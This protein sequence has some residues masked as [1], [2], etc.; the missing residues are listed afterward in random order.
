MHSLWSTFLQQSAPAASIS[1]VY[2]LQGRN[3]QAPA[4]Y[5][6]DGTVNITLPLLVSDN[7]RPAD[8]DN[9]VLFK[10]GKPVTITGY[11]SLDLTEPNSSSIDSLAVPAFSSSMLDEE[12][13]PQW[14]SSAAFQQFAGDQLP[15]SS[16]A[17]GST[18]LR[19]GAGAVTFY[20]QLTAEMDR[21]AQ[22]AFSFL[23]TPVESFAADSVSSH[24][25]A[26]VP[27]VSSSS[28]SMMGEVDV[29]L[30]DNTSY[31]RIMDPLCQEV[32]LLEDLEEMS[33]PE[34]SAVAALTAARDE[35]I[36][37]ARCGGVLALLLIS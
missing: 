2:C 31:T 20:P 23:H 19:S 3:Q 29:M 9:A 35:A 5:N 15:T 1:L 27:D 18:Q 25:T 34:I 14:M 28:S 33:Q 13:T 12:Y 17:Y 4:V 32:I 11:V 36:A 30:G 26:V 6:R 22:P 24:S 10:N 7:L 37:S 16:A 8:S 21:A